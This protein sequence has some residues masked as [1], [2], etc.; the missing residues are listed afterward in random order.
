MRAKKDPR[1]AD[2]SSR[3]SNAAADM[4]MTE[5]V[6]TQAA[7]PKAEKPVLPGRSRVRLTQ[8][9]WFLPTLG[10]GC[11]L[12]LAAVMFS[13]GRTIDQTLKQ[14]RQNQLYSD[15]WER[16]LESNVAVKG[17]PAALNVQ[18]SPTFPSVSFHAVRSSSEL[19]RT[20]RLASALPGVDVINLCRSR[21]VSL[22]EA[23]RMIRQSKSSPMA[24]IHSIPST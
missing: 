7:T 6:K 18:G 2:L 24:S 15:I 3:H 22:V 21:Y 16:L 8:Q 5:P 19:Y 23:W 10:V 11:A 4:P 9:P 13:A 14:N 12:L 1:L 17:T 20:L